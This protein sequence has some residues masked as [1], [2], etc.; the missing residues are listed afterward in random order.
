VNIQQ[1]ANHIF[2]SS[3]PQRLGGVADVSHAVWVSRCLQSLWHKSSIDDDDIVAYVTPIVARPSFADTTRQSVSSA[4][5]TDAAIWDTETLNATLIDG[6][7]L[8][9][10]GPP[11][12]SSADLNSPS[13]FS[14]RKRSVDASPVAGRDTTDSCSVPPSAVILLSPPPPPKRRLSESIHGPES[15]GRTINELIDYIHEKGQHGLVK[16]YKLL[17]EEGPTGTFEASKYDVMLT[18]SM[19]ELCCAVWYWLVNV[20]CI[21]ISSVPN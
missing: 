6:F 15:C 11:S 7:N 13:W 10:D 12:S 2:V 4:S 3:L 21:S 5:P 19:C 14:S 20:S 17:K 9:W 16:E 8:G 18:L 1:L